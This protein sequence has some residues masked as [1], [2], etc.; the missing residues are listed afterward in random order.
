MSLLFN[1]VILIYVFLLAIIYTQLIWSM[2]DTHFRRVSN[3]IRLHRMVGY[4]A[5][6]GAGALP[7]RFLDLPHWGATLAISLAVGFV[8]RLLTVY[9]AL[10]FYSLE[11]EVT[12]LYIPFLVVLGLAL[13]IASGLYFGLATIWLGIPK[14]N[15]FAAPKVKIERIDKLGL[16][17]VW[18]LSGVMLLFYGLT[19]FVFIPQAAVLQQDELETN[20]FNLIFFLLYVGLITLFNLVQTPV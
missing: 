16:D 10:D 3:D 8:V 15:S 17:S 6:T 13:A 20:L 2:I 9:L 7:Y 5:H 19:A 12:G 1:A 14:G 18:V 11:Y 4:G